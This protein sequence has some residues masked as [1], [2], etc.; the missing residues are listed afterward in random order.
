M[1]ILNSTALHL[2]C[3]YD[4][5]LWLQF[6]P[7]KNLI[8]KLIWKP[9]LAAKYVNIIFKCGIAIRWLVVSV[10]QG[11]FPPIFSINISIV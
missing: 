11:S 8:G 7:K 5:D 6:T 1:S 4:T 2:D 3:N 10:A 9:G